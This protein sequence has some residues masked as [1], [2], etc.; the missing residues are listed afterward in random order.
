MVNHGINLKSF[1]IINIGMNVDEN[2]NDG[3]L[4]LSEGNEVTI[5]PPRDQSKTKCLLEIQTKIKASDEK[6]FCIQLKSHAYFL[7]EQ[8]ETD[9]NEFV[10]TECYPIAAKRIHESIKMITAAAGLNPLDLEEAKE[11]QEN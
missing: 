1:R 9:F 11:Q 2:P 3:H 10:K 7:F 4:V 5:C 6:E 8:P